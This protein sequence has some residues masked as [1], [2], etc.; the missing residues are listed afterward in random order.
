MKHNN[1]RNWKS[2]ILLMLL[3]LLPVISYAQN[4]NKVSGMVSDDAGIPMVGVSVSE[5]G[6]A[7]GTVTDSNGKFNLTVSSNAM[8]GFSFVGYIHQDVPVAGKSQFN[9][10]MSEDSKAIEEVVVVGYGVQKKSSVTGAISKVG[11]G[12]MENRTIVNPVQALQGK[13]AGVQIIQTS[14]APGKSSTVR[15]RGFSSNSASNPLYVVD[16]LRTSDIGAIDPTNIESLEVL[17]DAASAA[18][19]GAQAGNGVILITTKK[20]QAG[21][22]KIN[23]DFQYVNNSLARIPKVMNASEYINYMTEGGLLTQTDIAAKWDGTTD[24]DW[25][26]VAFENSLMKKHN[27]G[28]QGGNEKGSYYMGLSYLNQDGIVKGDDDV[29]NRI[30]GMLNA[31]YAIK[32]WLKIGTTNTLEKWDMKSVSENSEYGSLLA[33]VL[34]MDPLTP[35]VYSADNLPA[36]MQTL[37]DGGRVLT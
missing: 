10:R 27:I 1:S 32:P 18:I 12:D 29:Y 35:D 26:D 37:L 17:K 7:N 15:V 19:Y 14:G 2:I 31:D 20:G 4:K 22:G 9:I 33:A 6:A 23:Y 16:G 13:T 3:L 11:S 5:K 28:F 24:T 25:T 36:F 8:L 30:T 21:F 34:T